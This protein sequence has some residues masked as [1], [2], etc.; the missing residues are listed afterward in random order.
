MKNYFDIANYLLGEEY[1]VTPGAGSNTI[2]ATDILRNDFNKI[3]PVGFPADAT[4]M[5]EKQLEDTVPLL[6]QNTLLLLQ[7]CKN[8]Y[9]DN[10]ETLKRLG[11]KNRVDD[12]N[13]RLFLIEKAILIKA[14]GALHPEN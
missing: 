12:L 11:Q 10:L 7:S 4:Q 6:A 9:E 14:Q 5:T 3:W 13:I 8:Q 2:P 1:S